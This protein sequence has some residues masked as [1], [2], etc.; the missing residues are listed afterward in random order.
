MARLPYWLLRLMRYLRNF[1]IAT[2]VGWVVWVVFIDDNNIFVVLSN[3]QKM[4]DLEQDRLYY[5]EQV[6][7]VKKERQEVF[8]NQAMVEKW[9]REKYLMRKPT[10]D[11]YVIVDEN[12]QSIEKLK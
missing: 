6:R 12:G 11:V 10:E 9:A 5:Q 4:K 7:L 8:G 3:R 2:L 1:Y